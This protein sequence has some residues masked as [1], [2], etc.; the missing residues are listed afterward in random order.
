[1][2]VSFTKQMGSL[3][4]ILIFIITIINE[5]ITW[6]CIRKY[7][8]DVKMHP[9]H[10]NKL[11]ETPYASKTTALDL[12]TSCPND[13]I[14]RHWS[15]STFFL[16]SGLFPDDNKPMIALMGTCGIHLRTD[17][18]VLLRISIGKYEIENC[19][20]KIASPRCN[21]FSKQNHV[22]AYWLGIIII[23]WDIMVVLTTFGF[24]FNTRI[25]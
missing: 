19:T 5:R 24:D 23:S 13:A 7:I 14:W 10:I 3:N 18:C 20:F 25:L 2:R 16:S 15:G 22:S 17:S 21:E 8:V 9:L 12:N 11:F 4:V 1:M 6:Q